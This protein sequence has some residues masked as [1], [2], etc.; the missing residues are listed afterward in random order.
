MR[1][2]PRTVHEY[3][4]DNRTTKERRKTMRRVIGILM[5]LLIAIPATI[6]AQNYPEKPIR[7][8]VAYTPGGGNDIAARLIAPK[9]SD[10]F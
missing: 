5:L 8:I 6:L 1:G 3:G 9:L 7:I 4:T 2:D 10:A